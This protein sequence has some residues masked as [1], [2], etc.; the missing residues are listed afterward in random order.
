[1]TGARPTGEAAPTRADAGAFSCRVCGNARGN[2]ALVVREMMF[3]TGREYPYVHCGSCGCVQIARLPDD[4]GADYPDDYYAWAPPRPPGRLRRRLQRAR[5][6]RV[7]DGRGWIGALAVAVFGVP[8]TL[9]W[10]RQA[11]VDRDARV[12]E[13]GCGAGARLAAMRDWGFTRL[14][15]I[16]PFVPADAPGIPGVTRRREAL[17]THRGRYDFVMMHHVLEHLADPHRAMR[18]LRDRLAPDGV[19]LVR[20]PLADS[21]AFERYGV[22]WVQ[23]DAPRHLHVH[24]RRSLRVLADAAGLRI[25]RVACDSTAFQFWASERYRRGQ[26]LVDRIVATAPVPDVSR[27]AL[28][29]MARRAA[30]LNAA[31]R[32]DQAAVWL[33][34]ADLGAGPP[35][36]EGAAIP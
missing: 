9:A 27:R 5:A 31:G 4:P 26:P 15:G 2:R 24:T 19:A 11:G 29:R 20:T 34:R 7:L 21:E 3:G 36:A 22:H 23:L 13:V 33:R 10:L 28:R 25:E 30:R 16:D 17:E 6:D 14:T 35:G 32:G 8:D 12:L 18:A 1:M